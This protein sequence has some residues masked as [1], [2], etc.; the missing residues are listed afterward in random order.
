[1]KIVN[2]KL[3]PEAFIGHVYGLKLPFWRKVDKLVFHHTS[4]PEDTWRGSASMLH[5]YNL[6]C[7][8]GWKS[9]PHIFVGPDGIW[10]FTPMTKEG[11]HAGPNGRKKS[12]GIEIVGRYFDGPPTSDTMCKYIAV[13][14]AVLMEK[15]DLQWHQVFNHTQFEQFSN[16]SP[17]LT[18]AWLK[19]NMQKHQDFIE[20]KV[21]GF[22]A[23]LLEKESYETK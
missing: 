21:A 20:Q 7:S 13:V 6:Y 10:L 11:T 15:F 16:C 19:E 14:T 18:A 4:S 12:I 9:G 3:S 1:M 22:Q 23:S 2:K 5:Y 17:H 8:R